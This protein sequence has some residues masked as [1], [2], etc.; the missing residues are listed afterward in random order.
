LEEV[1]DGSVTYIMLSCSDSVFLSFSSATMLPELVQASVSG[2]IGPDGFR[3]LKWGDPPT[4]D[5]VFK[6]SLGSLDFLFKT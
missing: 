4:E 5:M 3:D 1:W 6:E 2:K